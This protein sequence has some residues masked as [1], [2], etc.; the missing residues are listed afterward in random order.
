[1]ARGLNVRESQAAAQSS[2]DLSEDRIDRTPSEPE[3]KAEPALRAIRGGQAVQADTEE[4]T[5]APRAERSAPMESDAQPA[6]TTAPAEP[7]RRSLRKPIAIGVLLIAIGIGVFYGYGWW[8]S[9]RFMISTDDAYVGADMALIAPKISGYVKS[10]PVGNNVHVTAGTPLLLLDD[11]D[12]RVA[13]QQAEAQVTAQQATIARIDRQVAAG[14]AQVN[15]AEAELASAQALATN[16]KTT[17]D[18]A[19]ALA[20]K[21]VGTQQAADD[22]RAAL[23]QANAGVDAS[24]AGV[25][26]AQA[27]VAVLIAQK[28]EAERVLDQYALVVAK[29]QLD[30]DHTVVRAPFEGV[31]GNKAAE[32][33][34]YVQ[35]GQRLMALVPL[36]DV[37]I[38][39]NFKE[40]QLEDLKPGQTVNISVDAYP[41]RDIEGTVLSVAPASGSV[42]TL[43]PP[44]NATGNFT[45]VVQRVPVRIRVPADVAAQDLIRPGM[46]V[47]V[48]VDTR[49]S[50]NSVAAR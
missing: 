45:K 37:Y 20:G 46:S 12:Y 29:A 25:N 15:Q 42:F 11:S 31:V 28:T 23:L 33:G 16:A 49:A 4:Q 22:A 5:E 48:A 39:A 14:N 24:R 27:N 38:D 3:R 21:S 35:P 44:D 32:P 50:G 7:K 47:V 26:T 8:T 41:D 9:G 2:G 34:E 40:T 43:L 36:Q 6:P 10:V 18:R 30:L 19:T 1:M 17:S 13:F